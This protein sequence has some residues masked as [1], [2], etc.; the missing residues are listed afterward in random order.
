VE[1]VGQPVAADQ[2]AV[3]IENAKTLE[4]DVRARPAAGSERVGDAVL[5]IQGRRLLIDQRRQG[6]WTGA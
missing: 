2:H 4:I 6:D 5:E 1:G 3:A